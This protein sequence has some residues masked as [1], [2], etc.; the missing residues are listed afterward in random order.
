MRNCIHVNYNDFLKIHNKSTILL[1]VK[2]R[3][4]ILII[5]IIQIT[6]EKS[7]RRFRTH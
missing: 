4:Q 5:R 2:I 1:K 3:K 7:E 6:K